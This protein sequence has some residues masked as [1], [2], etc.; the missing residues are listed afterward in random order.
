MEPASEED[1]EVLQAYVK[2][3]NREAIQQLLDQRD[4]VVKAERVFDLAINTTSIALFDELLR[5]NLISPTDTF[6][7]SK[8]KGGAFW[9]GHYLKEKGI[10]SYVQYWVYE[11]KDARAWPFLHHVVRSLL[12]YAKKAERSKIILKACSR[13]DLVTVKLIL[14]SD[15]DFVETLADKMLQKA[16]DSVGDHSVE[17]YLVDTLRLGGHPKYQRLLKEEAAE[18]AIRNAMVK[19]ARDRELAERKLIA[20]ER[21]ASSTKRPGLFSKRKSIAGGVK[22]RK[23]SPA[24]RRR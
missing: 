16:W 18:K 17:E 5:R 11:R 13:D 3:N 6:K 2:R 19:E 21:L 15:P 23:R 4:F 10:I 20:L 22:R 9:R 1:M 12:P 8:N 7:V 24:R 14:A